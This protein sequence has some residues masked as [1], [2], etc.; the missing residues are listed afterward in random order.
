[1]G[2]SSSQA[3]E[4]KALSILLIV[5][6]SYGLWLLDPEERKAWSD[7]MEVLPA[8]ILPTTQE[9]TD[10]NHVERQGYVIP[11][12]QVPEEDV[13]GNTE[14]EKKDA[15][16][17]ELGK[18]RFGAEGKRSKWGPVLAER[19]ST[20]IQNDGRTSLEKAKDNKKKRSLGGVLCQR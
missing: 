1:L 5:V 17:N 20:I 18:E 13:I 3:V 4:Q 2:N 16:D 10:P 12:K 9:L 11:D 7:F 19:K 6:L 15:G 14:G 8:D